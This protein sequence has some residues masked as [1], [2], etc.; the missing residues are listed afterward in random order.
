M[1]DD[2]KI[3]GVFFNCE[4][5]FENHITTKTRATYHNIHNIVLIAEY[6]SISLKTL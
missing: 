4:L 1:V 2:D 6:R 5:N 3:L